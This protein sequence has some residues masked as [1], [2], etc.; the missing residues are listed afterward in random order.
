MWKEEEEEEDEN[1]LNMQEKRGG[2]G[3]GYGGR[4]ETGMG[5]NE[6]RLLI[7]CE[8][9]GRRLWRLYKQRRRGKNEN[10]GII[11]HT[12]FS[13]YSPPYLAQQCTPLIIIS[14]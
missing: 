3:Y 12:F 7:G 8:G 6:R 14:F 13:Y 4:M 10:E 11:I 1:G 5:M 9:G 2:Y